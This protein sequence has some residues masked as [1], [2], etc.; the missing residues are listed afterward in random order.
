MPIVTQKIPRNKSLVSHWHKLLLFKELDFFP[1][2]H[3]LWFINSLAAETLQWH[4]MPASLGIQHVYVK[5]HVI[6]VPWSKSPHPFGGSLTFRFVDVW[7]NFSLRIK[8]FELSLQAFTSLSSWSGAPAVDK[9]SCCLG[10]CVTW[11][12]QGHEVTYT[13]HDSEKGFIPYAGR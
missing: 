6:S 11:S 4:L 3:N 5:L 2:V 8:W 1:I 13:C 10:Q 7:Y 12:A 9:S